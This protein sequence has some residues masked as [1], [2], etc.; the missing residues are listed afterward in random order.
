MVLFF[1]CLLA[2]RSSNLITKSEVMLHA[3]SF[4]FVFQHVVSSL[5]NNNSMNQYLSNIWN[6]L[7]LLTLS[8][9]VIGSLH[10]IDPG[11]NS[12][13]VV[14]VLSRL[15]LSCCLLCA[16]AF[17]LHFLVVSR[18]IGPKLIM[19]ITIMRKDML[20]YMAII[21]VFWLMFSIFTISMIFKPTGQVGIQEGLNIYTVVRTYFFSMFGEFNI[22]SNV[23]SIRL[24]EENCFRAGD[25]TFYGA[26]FIF[27]I[28]MM[29][30]VLLTHV[31]LLNLLIAMFTAP[32]LPFP[33]VV[34]WPFYSVCRLI[35]RAYQRKPQADTPFCYT[36]DES[37]QRQIVNWQKFRSLDYL[38]R[39]PKA[40]A[41]MKVQA[42]DIRSGNKDWWLELDSKTETQ[43]SQ[44][45]AI[46]AKLSTE[47]IETRLVGLEMRLAVA[48]L[49]SANASNQAPVRLMLSVTLKCKLE[50][51]WTKLP[52]L[53]LY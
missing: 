20:P 43:E 16:C 42:R 3:F 24:Y 1:Y 17:A 50:T 33:Y 25:C 14:S 15:F 47:F 29:V 41:Q 45:A 37:Q 32:P 28:I 21:C 52:L 30:Y 26:R 13:K 39:H 7:V 35:Y 6:R 51:N 34:V 4:F 48:N 38:H 27:P 12:Y 23:E 10:Y 49:A 5:E 36:V 22:P 19:I 31:L 18:Y 44:I 11:V 9:Y 8:F 2:I 40:F 53:F 46:A